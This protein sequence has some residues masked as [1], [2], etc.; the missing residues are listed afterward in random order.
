[1]LTGESVP[2][3]KVNLSAMYVR[4]CVC[5]CVRAGFDTRPK[6][7]FFSL[8]SGCLCTACHGTC[9]CCDAFIGCSCEC[10]H[11]SCQNVCMCAC[12]RACVLLVKE[13]IDGV[14]GEQVLDIDSLGRLHVIYGG[15]KVV[16]HTAPPKTV[17]GIRR[18]CMCP[19]S[20]GKW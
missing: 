13:P 10:S 15:T 20:R 6:W 16:Q 4:A 9:A 19:A 14:S 12:V 3:M 18:K 1:M 2:Q 5:A 17:S 11:A 8:P 7:S